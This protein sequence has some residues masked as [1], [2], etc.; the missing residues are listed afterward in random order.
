MSQ[1][2]TRTG[3]EAK[4][5]NGQL[6]TAP[7][8]QEEPKAPSTPAPKQKP[9]FIDL[10]C[11]TE[12]SH[13]CITPLATIPQRLIDR[14]IHV[15]AI[16]DH[17]QIWGAQKLAQ[18]IHENPAWRDRLMII[19]GEEISTTEGEI[20]G[21]FLTELVPPHMTP[22][23]TVAAIKRQG[24][25]V[26]IPHGF[27]PLKRHR[28]RPA[29]RERIKDSI[30]IIEV[31]N[32]RVSRSRWNKAAGDWAHEHKKGLAA[33]S[34]SHTWRDLGCCA[35]ESEWEGRKLT[36]VELNAA[37]GEEVAKDVDMPFIGPAGHT[38]RISTPEELLAALAVAKI[39]GIWTHPVWAFVMKS[40]YWVKHKLGV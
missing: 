23:E 38:R 35:S 39:N 8:L 3:E 26:S 32:A 34:D 4:V 5:S 10:H 33:G 16:T 20:I 11:H 29:A 15:Q 40:V 36:E 30:D 9:L 7:S 1:Q 6:G 28:L 13:D 14:G 27:D 18:M 19:I 31:F 25:L 21:L 12:A 24:G 37:G 2:T 22:E 17:D